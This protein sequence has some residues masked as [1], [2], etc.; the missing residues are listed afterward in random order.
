MIWLA[1]LLPVALGGVCIWLGYLIQVK[2]RIGL[3]HDYHH[4]NVKKEDITAYCR[5]MGKAMYIIGGTVAASGLVAVFEQELVMNILIFGGIAVAL[6]V[7]HK[8]QKRY[9][10]G[11]FS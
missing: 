6:L 7:M 2:E 1:S 9:N 5:E 11:W 4:R 10:G 3:I 8:A